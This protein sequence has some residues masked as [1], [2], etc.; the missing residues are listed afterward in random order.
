[1]TARAQGVSNITR[2]TGTQLKANGILVL[3]LELLFLNER[4]PR[5]SALVS[6][7]RK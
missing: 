3:L 1:M 5:P 7:E 4:L 2:S 6:S